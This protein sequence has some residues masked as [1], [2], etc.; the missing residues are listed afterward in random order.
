MCGRSNADSTAH[1]LCC[2]VYNFT[3]TEYVNLTASCIVRAEVLQASNPAW[4]DSLPT[5]VEHA[6]DTH[7]LGRSPSMSHPSLLHLVYYHTCSKA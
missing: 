6:K 1:I 3:N 7:T 4:A 2:L 5:R